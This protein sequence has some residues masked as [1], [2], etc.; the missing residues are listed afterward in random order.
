MDGWN[1]SG[2]STQVQ[3]VKP[4]QVS[5]IS[6]KFANG[7]VSL[8]SFVSDIFRGGDAYLEQFEKAIVALLC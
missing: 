2:S 3:P 5:Q 4:M 1:A 8:K 6:E 7:V